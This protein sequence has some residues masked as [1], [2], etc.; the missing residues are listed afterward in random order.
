MTLDTHTK[1]VAAVG[2]A[3]AISL[4]ERAP[5]HWIRPGLLFDLHTLLDE[6]TDNEPNPALKVAR[7]HARKLVKD[8][9]PQP[10]CTEGDTS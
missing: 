2:L 10:S 7:N 9:E 1:Q 5:A 6:L 3:Y 4:L 8:I